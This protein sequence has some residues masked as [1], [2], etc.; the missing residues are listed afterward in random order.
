MADLIGED[1]LQ[2]LIQINFSSDNNTLGL[3]EGI[4]LDY[5]L[6]SVA[7]HHI[8]NNGGTYT[9]LDG[10]GAGQLNENFSFGSPRFFFN[11]HQTNETTKT[12][13]GQP[14]NWVLDKAN[15]SGY[16]N[17]FQNGQISE[18]MLKE[19]ARLILAQGWYAFYG[20]VSGI[21]PPNFPE[22][23]VQAVNGFGE[24][25]P[26]PLSPAILALG[27]TQHQ[28]PP[29][30]PVTVYTNVLTGTATIN[31]QQVYNKFYKKKAPPIL[32]FKLATSQTGDYGL[33]WTSKKFGSTRDT[34]EKHSSGESAGPV[35]YLIQYTSFDGK[36]FVS[37]Q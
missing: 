20:P 33:T 31:L 35:T 21:T 12:D 34:V 2:T 19:P 6:T 30:P 10:H 27:W 22:F 1:F 9:M 25:I 32:Q 8:T 4:T 16:I 36:L 7:L 15:W 37:K 18:V 13:P 14:G 23:T 28:L 17:G 3:D 29:S 11:S 26:L 24:L 5:D